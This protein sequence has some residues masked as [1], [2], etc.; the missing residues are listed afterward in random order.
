MTDGE[1]PGGDEKLRKFLGATLIAA[2]SLIVVSAGLCTGAVV[3]A[4]LRGPPNDFSALVLP[5]MFGGLPLLFGLLLFFI[6]RH[7]RRDSPPP[8][9]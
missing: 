1:V 5:L 9:Q 2:G 6:G 7:L 3:S 8:K 4:D